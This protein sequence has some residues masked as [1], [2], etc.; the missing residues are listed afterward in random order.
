MKIS[1]FAYSKKGIETAK[2]VMA[3]FAADEFKAYA[4]ARL[5]GDVFASDEDVYE[6]AFSESD[7]MIFVGAT[8]I[9][10]RKIAPYVKDKTTDPAVICVDELAINVIPVLSGHIGGANEIASKLADALN[11]RAVITT[12]TDINKRFSVDAWAAKRGY[13]IDNLK[14]AKDI[15][16]AILEEDIPIASDFHISSGYPNGLYPRTFGKLGILISIY[17]KNPYGETLHVIPKAVN[18]GIGCRKGV[19]KEAIKDA[20]DDFLS[21]NKISPLSVKGFASI[22]LKKDE[23]GL[24][25]YCKEKGYGIEFYPADEL[26]KIE[27]CCSASEF[28]LGITGVDNVCERAALT[29]ADRLIES[30]TVYSGIT[31]AAAIKDIEVSFE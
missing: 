18:I 19:T 7:A 11:S 12:A 22:D 26:A 16:A 4:P 23:E 31:L 30:K 21:V 10:V 5:A 29:G 8:G 24:L 27:G 2:R 3:L 15:S 20:V 6:A 25:A 17:N 13:A 28:V 14:A 1:V 9:A